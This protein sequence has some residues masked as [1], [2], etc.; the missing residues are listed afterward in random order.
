MEE[1]IKYIISFLLEV[2]HN[3]RF[4]HE[5]GYTANKDEF[6]KYKVVIIPSGFFENDAYGTKDSLSTLPLQKIEN[7]PFL[8]GESKIETHNNTLVVHADIIASAF[9]FLSQYEEWV[10]P[11]VRDQHGRF[12]GKNSIA[13]K[14]GFIE[15]P[16][17]DEYGTLLRKWLQEKDIAFDEPEHRIKK[18]YLTHDVD[19]AF[20]Y[21]NLRNIMGSII[22]T[23]KLKGNEISPA[24]KTFCGK[25]AHDPFFS[26]P[27]ILEANK[28]LSETTETPVE[29]I[30]F[31]KSPTKKMATYDHP[32]YDLSSN[33]VQSLFHL[34]K[35]NHAK[36]GLHGSYY[37]K[38]HPHVLSKE[39][40]TLDLYSK[41]K[42]HYN[43]HH[44]LRT[45]E[46]HQLD[47]LIE[48]GIKE[49]FSYGY[50]DISGFRLGTTHAVNWINPKTKEVN[51]ELL[52]HPLHIMDVTLTREE[53][54]NLSF[55]DSYDHA[56]KIINQVK[57]HNGELS[58]LFHNNLLTDEPNNYRMLYSKILDYLSDEK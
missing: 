28:R 2:R 33:D 53:Y 54:M 4:L 23:I 21:R 34:C 19:E 26:Y 39:K 40:N 11:D 48:A 29:S 18:I 15:K 46:A 7:I 30:F 45:L 42:V 51:L 8:Y 43:R 38:K 35:N 49:D 3:S 56:V 27:W 31:F 17:V 32:S 20:K 50:A 44:Y 24:L 55:I 16:I 5:V 52:L 47:N 6:D 13:Y 57:R 37:S 22:R 12:L 36:I 10:Q 14:E 41:H 25:V 58:I 9:F 1:M